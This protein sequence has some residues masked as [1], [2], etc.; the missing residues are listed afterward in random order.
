MFLPLLWSFF[1]GIRGAVEMKSGKKRLFSFNSFL[2]AFS[3]VLKLRELCVMEFH[4]LIIMRC[5]GLNGQGILGLS[6]E[7]QNR[8]SFT[9]ISNFQLNCEQDF[10]FLFV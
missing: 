5:L 6:I 4:W 3:V 10:L 7:F 9:F 2:A 8:S 1:V